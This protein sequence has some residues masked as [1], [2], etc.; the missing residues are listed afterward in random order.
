MA[1]S[2]KIKAG[3]EIGDTDLFLGR[4]LINAHATSAVG[5]EADIPQQGRD[6]RF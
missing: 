5:G 6:F 3:E 4:V 2:K 1:G